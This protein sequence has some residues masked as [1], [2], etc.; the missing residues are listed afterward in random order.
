[1]TMLKGDELYAQMAQHAARYHQAMA[2][3]NLGAALAA[4]EDA[5][6]LLAANF[7]SVVAALELWAFPASQGAV[8]DD[9]F[10]AGERTPF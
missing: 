3:H 5:A 1:M 4:R 10:T 2:G 6:R 7:A 9:E 8:P